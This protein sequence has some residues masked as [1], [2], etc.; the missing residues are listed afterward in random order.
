MYSNLL[1]DMA[2]ASGL[3]KYLV[4]G[5]FSSKRGDSPLLLLN[6]PHTSYR[7]HVYSSL[8]FKCGGGS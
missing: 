2:F 6:A 3:L 4:R 1:E 5:A 7:D 8:H